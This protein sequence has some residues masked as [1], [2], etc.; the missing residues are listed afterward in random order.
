MRAAYERDGYVVIPGLVPPEVLAAVR[1]QSS[2]LLADSEIVD[3]NNLRCRYKIRPSD[4]EQLLDAID[5]VADLVP[6][7][8]E[9]AQSPAVLGVLRDLYGE[10]ARLFKDKLI[11]KPPGSPGYPWHQD[12]ISWPFFP[13]SFLTVMI[14]LDAADEGNGCLEVVKASHQRG[15]LS[16]RDG[17]FH[18][19]PAAGFAAADRVKIPLAPGDAVIF[20]CYLVHGSASN[21]SSGPRRHLYLSYNKESDGGDQRA[22]HYRYFHAWLRRRYQE[23]GAREAFFR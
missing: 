7:I 22:S 18:D 14:A 3:R 5:P 13:E 6:A 8:K 17:D 11:V 2:R 1:E 4:G 15:Y 20:G 23:Y 9:L 12:F 21:A 16:A 10:E 19:L